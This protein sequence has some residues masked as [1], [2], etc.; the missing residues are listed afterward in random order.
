LTRGTPLERPEALLKSALEKVVFF[1]C[2]LDQL[3]SDLSRANSEI[4]RL[5]SELSRA[6][7][8]EVQLRQELA[9][10]ESRAN[11]A[12]RER[13]EAL[14]NA[15]VARQE[16][17]RFLDRLIE[18]EQIRRAGEENEGIDLASFIA[19]LRS[20][21]L[22]L[23]AT[24]S[25][26]H[27]PFQPVR[28][29][30]STTV[31]TSRQHQDEHRPESQREHQD[32]DSPSLAP[33]ST[34]ASLESTHSPKPTTSATTSR[35]VGFRS[36]QDAA[37]L[38]ASQGRIGIGE[39]EHQALSIR[40]RFETR[41]EETLFFLSLRELAAS[42]SVSRMRA[43]QRLKSLGPRAALPAIAAAL[44]TE[45]SPEVICALMEVCAAAKENSIIPLLEIKLGSASVE[46]RL[47]ALEAVF[48]LQGPPCLARAM[49]DKSSRVRRRAAVLAA[50]QSEAI[51]VLE[52]A[53]GDADASVRRVAALGL[54][55]VGGA[56]AQSW[57]LSALD[58]SD[59]TV[60]RA[61]A[62][63]LSRSFGPQAF[64]IADLDTSRRRREIRRLLAQPTMEITA[65]AA[66]LT[67]PSVTPLATMSTTSSNTVAAP[68]PPPNSQLES[69]ILDIVYS[70]LRGQSQEELGRNL[71]ADQELVAA[72]V[73]SLLQRGKLVRRG[74]RYFVP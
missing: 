27:A 23:R 18:A 11:L 38:M 60:R 7:Q 37:T 63:G 61:A 5:K 43:A 41:S 19:E 66:N 21:V 50:G 33:A 10:S 48:R 40:A 54:A 14:E 69:D 30:V 8:L 67:S 26:Q 2:R 15:A 9:A 65:R 20:E 58:D 31:Q 22:H 29:V 39:Q 1:E 73:S 25:D 56:R 64:A 16:R 45:E 32:A 47:S 74:Q 13:D 70:A 42:D 34:A 4:E 71:K 62:K 28:S 68:C 12:K 53:A 35:I 52:Q 6:S 46:V 72:S 3:S 49:Q 51:S 55:A 44:N 17:E 24:V 57:L 59:V 36:T